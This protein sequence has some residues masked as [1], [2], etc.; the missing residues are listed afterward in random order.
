M[1]SITL[2]LFSLLLSLL[3]LLTG[4]GKKEGSTEENATVQGSETTIGTPSAR[5][6]LLQGTDHRECNLTIRGSTLSC[7]ERDQSLMLINLFASWCPPCRAEIP[8]LNTLQRAYAKDLFVIGILVND[9]MNRTQIDAFM[10]KYGGD[11]FVSN[12]REDRAFVSHLIKNLK[13]PE[14]YPIPLSILY[15]DGKLYR[16]YEGAMPIEMMKNE[17]DKALKKNRKD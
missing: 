1:R 11:Y 8:A 7:L 2:L 16:Y 13:L 9:E 14:N 6:F 12:T 5:S 15:R 4:C 3:I 10:E 17:I